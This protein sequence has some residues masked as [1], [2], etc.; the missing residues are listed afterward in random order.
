MDQDII[1]H[2]R[3]LS[4]CITIRLDRE[5]MERVLVVKTDLV[6]NVDSPAHD[7]ATFNNL[8]ETIRNFWDANPSIDSVIVEP[9]GN[10]HA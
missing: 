10:S 5:S 1:K 3:A 2:E 7:A 8:I 4:S 6:L 9:L